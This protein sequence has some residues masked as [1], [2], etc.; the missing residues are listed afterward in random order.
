MNELIL[1]I[2]QDP[3]LWEIVERLKN[4]DEDLEDFIL[5]IAQMFAVE[6]QELDRSDLDD[7]LDSLFGGLPAKIKILAPQFL[8]IALDLYMQ[9]KVTNSNA[10]ASGN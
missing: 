3:E 4:Q 8:H 5:G 1:M 7:K 6:F 10:Y 9:T 2:Q